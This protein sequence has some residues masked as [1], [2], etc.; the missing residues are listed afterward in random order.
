MCTS[1]IGGMLEGDSLNLATRLP[2]A[3]LAAVALAALEPSCKG[4]GAPPGTRPHLMLAEMPLVSPGQGG[5][6]LRWVRISLDWQCCP[7]QG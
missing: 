4:C 6:G 5:G 7:R 2:F 3:E 1:R